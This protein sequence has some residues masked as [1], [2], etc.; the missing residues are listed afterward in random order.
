MRVP[1]QLL[2]LM[3]GSVLS[4]VVFADDWATYGNGLDN[5]RFSSLKEVNRNN[6][7]QLQLAW[8]FDSGI[9][10]S[11]QTSP[12]KVGDRLYISTPFN[13]VIALDAGTGEQVWRYEY[14]KPKKKS[15]CGPANRGVAVAK[16]KVFQATIDGQLIALDQATGELVWQNKVEDLELSVQESIDGLLQGMDLGGGAKI[17]GGTSHSFNMAPQVYKDM[18]IVGSTGAGY[19]LHLDTEKGLRV[20]G[21]GDGRT[22]LRG[23]L[24]AFDM[25]TGKE[26]WRWYSVNG[27]HWVGDW[28][29]TTA[30]GLTLNRDIATEKANAQ[31]FKHSWKLGGGS[32]WTT[33][34]IDEETGWLFAGTGNPAPNMDS[35]TRP[36]DNLHTSSIVA[37]DSKN[38]KL[39]WAFQQV[40]HDRWGYDV[41]SPPVLFDTVVAGQTVKAVGQAGKTGWF[42]VLNRETGEL[43]FKSEP[44]V[45]QVNLFADPTEEGVTIAP[46]IAGG[47][48]W[49]P[50]SVNPDKQ[51]VYIAGIHLPA[52]YYRKPLKL[53]SELP[54]QTYSYFEFDEKQRYGTLTAINLKS[55]KVSWQKETRLPM[56]GGTLATAGDLVFSGEGDGE[57]FAVDATTGEKLWS[58]KQSYGVN[59]PPV[60]YSHNGRQY[61]AVAA[62]GNKIAGYPTGDSLL[63]FSLLRAAK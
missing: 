20:V 8:K 51:Q 6:V 23:F 59:A 42:Y 53:N 25:E 57:F 56:L 16:G 28:Q 36:G 47:S 13:H 17:T 7:D 22:G 12:I 24:S 1:N 29:E 35:S 33:P 63:V 52:T 5:Q 58:Y 60:S 61:I 50:V 41:S 43:L 45:P 3:L 21:I 9:K 10:A 31:R 4:Q 39:K 11:F 19:G 2:G 34:A 38:G 62:G 46:G 37:I 18:V 15:C 44:F 14:P 54:W 30:S 49:S 32:V 55:G 40:P 27:E 26:L 48:N